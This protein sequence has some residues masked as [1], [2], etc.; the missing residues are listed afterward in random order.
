MAGPG[1]TA[2]L[3]ALPLPQCPRT[4]VSGCS[5][6]TAERRTTPRS[7][8]RVADVMRQRPGHVDASAPRPHR[9]RRRPWRRAARLTVG[10]LRPRRVPVAG[11]LAPE[12]CVRSR[13]A[14]AGRTPRRRAGP[15]DASARWRRSAAPFRPPRCPGCPFE[16]D[17]WRAAFTRPGLVGWEALNCPAPAKR[18]SERRPDA[19]RSRG[20]SGSPR[21]AARTAS[22]ASTAAAKPFGAA[23]P[24]VARPAGLPRTGS[25]GTGS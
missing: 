8:R 7:G 2:Q 13:A 14:R 22:A 12:R 1:Y 21:G 11:D 24:S 4:H 17:S 18:T 23:R 19:G 9:W 15:Y 16:H 25:R 5:C 20:R 6:R 3:D 10:C